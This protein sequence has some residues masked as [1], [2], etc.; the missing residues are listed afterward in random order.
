MD[1]QVKIDPSQTHYAQS[2]GTR[3]SGYIACAL[4][5][6]ER[7]RLIY[8]AVLALVVVGHFA[9]A[10]PQSQQRLS[11]DLLL[12]MFVLAVLANMLYCAVYIVDLF[13]QFS[14]LEQ[15]WRK[16]RVVLL[17]VGTAFAAIMAHYAAMDMFAQ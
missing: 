7:K 6:W 2:S 3:L 10:W 12:G 17:I 15:A 8:N 14:G 4:R 16:G 1:E 11:I 9:A 13:V 5:Y